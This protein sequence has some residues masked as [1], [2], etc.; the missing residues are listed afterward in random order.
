MSKIV[1]PLGF[2]VGAIS[3]LVGL[4][5]LFATP[6]AFIQPSSFRAVSFGAAAMMG[7]LI[8][9]VMLYAHGSRTGDQE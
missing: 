1:M 6:D 8:V 9:L 3:Y 2:I 4:V 5:G 7:V